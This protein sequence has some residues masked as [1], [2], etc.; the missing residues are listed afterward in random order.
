MRINPGDRVRDTV[1]GFEGICICR[2]EY[3]SGCARVGLQPAST[4]GKLPEAMYFDEPMCE[5]ITP[6]AVKAKPTDNGGPRD[7][8]KQHE[9]P[10]R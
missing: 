7:V 8:P 10:R 1:S 3:V 4:D 5:V 9:A 6:A 2:S